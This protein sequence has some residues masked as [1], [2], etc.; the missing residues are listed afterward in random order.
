MQLLVN[1]KNLRP[2]LR[3][4]LI[5]ALRLQATPGPADRHW[6]TTL[7][8]KTPLE[9]EAGK[10]LRERLSTMRDDPLYKVL[11]VRTATDPAER[12]Q[13]LQQ[14]V[15]SF[16]AQR[17]FDY[18][19][20]Q[21]AAALVDEMLASHAEAPATK[22]LAGRALAAELARARGDLAAAAAG[23]RALF[24]ERPDDVSILNKLLAM[25]DAAGDRDGQVAALREHLAKTAQVYPY[26]AARLAQLLLDLGHPADALDAL[27]QTKDTYGAN[28]TLRLEA[29]TAL[30]DPARRGREARAWLQTE[31]EQAGKRRGR[32]VTFLSIQRT[33]GPPSLAD[34]LAPLPVPAPAPK[35]RTDWDRTRPDHELLAFL[36]EGE[37]LARSFLRT[38]T[39]DERDA[40]PALYRGWIGSA[41]HNG[42]A[43]AILAGMRAR[44]AERSLDPEALRTLYAAAQVGLPVEPEIL[45]REVRRRLAANPS[46]AFV[47]DALVL[48]HHR[49]FDDLAK[50]LLV[51][52]LSDRAALGNQ[53]L[54]RCCPR[55]SASPPPARPNACSSYC[56][57][58]SR[59]T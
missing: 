7:C 15:Q 53:Q 23:Y 46:P 24:T 55:S 57:A 30:D 21:V 38:M 48:A 45:E 1:Q 19:D 2:E 8:L 25:L 59:R 41:A 36:P 31:Q 35:T 26:Q 10:L 13:R 42:H 44:L 58:R 39:N 47:A 49:G 32:M 9:P 17:S 6:I 11:A 29:L 27:A 16:C 37:E 33:K 40:E 34:T 20:Q 22:T 51:P 12:Q 52:L 3:L 4:A 18:A 5:D 56:P 54:Q 14:A 50:R 43:D 28:Q